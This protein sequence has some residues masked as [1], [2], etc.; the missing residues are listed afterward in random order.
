MSPASSFSLVARDL[1]RIRGGST[2]LDG[3]DVSVG[4]RTRLGVVGPN[5]VGKTTLLRLLAGLDRPDRGSV[6][7][8]PPNARV[9]YLPQEPERSPHETL[10]D[11]LARRTGVQAANAELERTAAALATQA[12]DA[13]DAYV[14]A[15]DDYLAAGGPDF[16]ARARVTCAD[17]GLSESFLHAPTATLS[18]GQAARASLAAILVSR[19]DVYLLDEPTNDLDFAGLARLERFLDEL[20]GGVVVVSHDRTFLERVVTRVLELDEHDRSSTEFGGGWLGYLEARATARRHAEEEYAVYTA[21]RTRLETRAR[22]QRQWAA[23]GVRAAKTRA[24]DHD[25]AQRDFRINA[26]ERQASKARATEQAIARLEAVDKPW[27]G[28]DLRFTLADAPRSGDVVLRL[29]GAVIERGDFRLGPVDLEIGWAERVA[30]VGA[31]GSGKT[32]LLHALLGDL[33]LA[34]G[35]RRMGPGVIVGEMDQAR[36]AFA[37]DRTLLDGFIAATGLLTGEARSLLAKFGLGADH[38]LRR[39]ATL[40]PGERTRAVLARFAAQGVNCLVLDEPT[41]HLDLP[42][43]QQLEAALDGYDG[44]L[45]LVSHDRALLEAVR[46]TR[47]ITASGEP[48]EV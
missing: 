38:V 41:N 6:T 22:T 26:S 23:D 11:F 3:V 19:F 39:T 1:A 12:A 4:P 45:L 13:D 16:E 32:T 31:N 28:W 10:L 48:V 30:I 7:R 27:E 33:P 40:S 20:A 15:L 29:D 8:T 25:K 2:V 34:A 44:T 43:I 47:A 24:P 37:D 14:R 21:Q 42:A 17:L 9:G 35:E 5:G 18:G 36:A 46:V